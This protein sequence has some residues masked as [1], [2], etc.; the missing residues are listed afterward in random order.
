MDLSR[1]SDEDLQAIQSGDMSKVSSGGLAYLAGQAAP[2]ETKGSYAQDVVSNLWPSAKKYGE[3]IINSV[4][5]PLDT[6][7]G[8][9]D[10]GAGA[11]QNALPESVV[12]WVGE[13]KPSRQV[14]TD[15]GHGLAHRY[16]G[17]DNV[18]ETFR[19]DPV[20]VV[21]DASMLLTGGASAA[22]MATMPR[23][24]AA[25]NTAATV[26]NPVNVINNPLV[27]KAGSFVAQAPTK[28]IGDVSTGAGAGALET[29][30]DAT[31]RG[32]AAA[33]DYWNNL[34]G[35]I[36]PDEVIAKARE[37]VANLRKTMTDQYRTLKNDPTGSKMGWADDPTPLS[38]NGVAQA[39]KDALDKYSFEGVTKPG[40][41]PVAADVKAVLDD[42]YTNAQTNPAFLSI[43]GLDALKQHL[44][45]IYPTDVANRTGR[46]FASDVVE[47]VKKTISAQAPTY[48]KSLHEYWN[49]ASE[50][51]DITRELS[52]GPTANTGTT[53]RK[54]QAIMR[55]NAGAGWEYR[56]SLGNKLADAGG[57]V[58]PS[59]AGQA[60]NSWTPRGMARYTDP[61]LL[62]GA[63]ATTGAWAPALAAAPLAS[64]RLMGELYGGLGT[65]ARGANNA[66]AGAANIVRPLTSRFPP[67][68]PTVPGGLNAIR[69][70]Q[71]LSQEQQ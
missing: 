35:N 60:L 65:V 26:T 44:G 2:K 40:V 47:G 14:A 41:A 31:K 37:G 50:L 8:V 56:K 28:I 34:R 66:K 64:P 33:K 58:G 13:D 23:T 71:E 52:L 68:L 11:L 30:Y 61:A 5:H 49:K 36:P 17:L 20:G 29:A 67:T 9:I 55:G 24:A 10:L 18:T 59:L 3:G 48:R 22:K 6:A 70:I 4:I 51:D 38:F 12:Q 45:S 63:G 7:K 32:G 69:S 27:R 15:V 43:E 21:G 42:W 1:L 39:Y 57:D 16:G 53:L 62:F 54:L 46:S 25:L 19:T